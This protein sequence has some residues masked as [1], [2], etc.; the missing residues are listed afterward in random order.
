LYTAPGPRPPAARARGAR[1]PLRD[2]A[3]GVQLARHRQSR[4][5]L[6]EAI[7]DPAHERRLALDDHQ[8]AV[9]YLVAEGRPAAHPHALG[10]GG[11]ELVPDALATDLPLEL[12]EAQQDVQRQPPHRGGGVELLGDADEGHVVALEHLHQPGEVHQRAA[13][14]VDLVDHHDV[15]QS[16]LDVAQQPLEPRPLQS[17]A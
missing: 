1:P 7:E 6:D 4:A 2:L 8:P 5:G 9:L 12:G 11:G 3:R 10:A 16:R 15:D 17:A 14:A 13:E